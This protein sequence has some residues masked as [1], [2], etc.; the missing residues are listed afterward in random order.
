[1]KKTFLAIS[2]LAAML[3]AGCTSSDE[4]TTLESIKTA[5]NTPTPVQFGTYMGATRS[6]ITGDITTKR[7]LANKGGFGVF[8]Y[9]TGN[10]AWK[11]LDGT[12]NPKVAPTF[13]YNQLISGSD[14]D[15]PAW[16][17]SPVKYWPNGIDAGNTSGTPSSTATALAIQY[18][19]FFAYA[20]YVS[21]STINGASNSVPADET[22]GITA[23]SG[24]T[25]VAGN[26]DGPKV[27]YKLAASSGTAMVDLMWGTRTTELYDETDNTQ[28]DKD[29]SGAY[30]DG[31]NNYYNT[32]LTKQKKTETIDFNFKHALTKVGGSDGFQ[33]V[34]DVEDNSETAEKADVTLVT[35]K[36]ITVQNVADNVYKEG[37]FDLATGTWSASLPT[38]GSDGDYLNLNLT[39][40]L[41]SSFLEP[42]AGTTTCPEY[43]TSSNKW[44][45][46]NNADGF[47]NTPFDGVIKTPA[48]VYASSTDPFYL[49]PGGGD[50]KLKVSVNYIVR[51]Y[52]TNLALPTDE[53]SKCSKVEQTITNTVTL[54]S[55]MIKPNK[56]VKLILHL[57]ISSV[58]FEAAV[59]D[60]DAI[61]AGTTQNVWLPSNVE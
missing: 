27:T 28:S 33:I 53:I 57:G 12:T 9:N 30:K 52:D 7:V 25:V 35:V 11:D 34:L 5:D 19:S 10:V 58:K 16:T 13:M 44:N 24:N 59:Q 39:S 21:L 3:F 36:S 51:T 48:N 17:Y 47:S 4:L 61:D 18:L 56:K 31:A 55:S 41:N 43:N 60:W 2:A 37:V 40:A 26:N 23:I 20:P 38:S 1:M 29:A 50:Q 32:D 49:I 42:A 14:N 46:N 15:S 8:A 6:G 54:T 22:V 45:T